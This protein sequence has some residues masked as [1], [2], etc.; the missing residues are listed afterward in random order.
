MG[1]N[2]YLENANNYL[3]KPV[4]QHKTKKKLDS[5]NKKKEV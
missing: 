4:Y 3:L 5:V 1:L 2:A